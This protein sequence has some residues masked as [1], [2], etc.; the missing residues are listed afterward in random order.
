VYEIRND[1]K[2]SSFAHSVRIE[3]ISILLNPKTNLIFIFRFLLV[4][5]G[6]LRPSYA[7]RTSCLISGLMMKKSN[8][9]KNLSVLF[10]NKVTYRNLD[11]NDI[12]GASALCSEAFDGPFRIY[13]FLQKKSSIENYR[14]QFQKRFLDYVQAGLKHAMIV[15]TMDG[16]VIG[17]VE[18]G[19]LPPPIGRDPSTEV[20]DSA[21][22]G[23]LAVSENHR[24]IGV[25]KN[26]VRI[27]MKVAEKWN[28]KEIYAA[29]KSKNFGARSLYESLGFLLVLKESENIYQ[30]FK[31]DQTDLRVY[32]CK[33]LNQLTS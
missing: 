12:D 32:Y 8:S 19:L 18:I 14:L 15:A 25:G 26:L 21:Y 7:S 10:Q 5:N 11:L 9:W 2:D 1:F 27:A 3:I 31:R 17:F 24:R 29:V 33:P 28:E 4:A 30:Q 23:N 6:K 13:E 20:K 22:I 16:I